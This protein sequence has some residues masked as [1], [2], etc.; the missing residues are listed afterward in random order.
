[1]QGY[2][3]S[4]K[5][6]G[7]KYKACNTC[8]EIKSFETWRSVACCIECYQLW[9]TLI[10]FNCGRVTADQAQAYIDTLELG[11]KEFGED[12]LIVMKRI[13]E[14]CTKK[15]EPVVTSQPQNQFKSKKSKHKAYR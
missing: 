15:E 3:H 11:E 10:E 9:M 14:N 5:V 13:K 6:C 12:I 1:M 2:T 7:K 8:N 4:C